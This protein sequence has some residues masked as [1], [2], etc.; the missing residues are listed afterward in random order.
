MSEK[1][2]ILFNNF[3]QI[4]L[5]DTPLIDVRAPIEFDKGAF[6]NAVNLPILNDEERHKVGIKY[7]KYGN[8]EATKLG[9]KLV[10]GSIREERINAWIDFI[11]TNN[12]ALLY[13]FRGGSRSKIARQWLLEKGIEITRLDGGYKAFRNFLL[14]EITG[15]FDPNIS[16]ITLGGHTGSGKTI[17]IKQLKNA[18][19]LEGL[20]NHR[21]SSFGNNVTPQPKQINFDNALAYEMIKFRHKNLQHLVVEDEGRNIGRIFMNHDFF[22]WFRSKYMVILDST[23]EERIENTYDEYVTKSQQE[24]IDFYDEKGLEM[25]YEYIKSSMIRVQKRLG[26]EKLKSFLSEFENAYTYQ[27]NTGDATKH[28][29]WIALFLR[30][31]YDPMYSYQIDESNRKLLFKGNKDEVIQFLNNLK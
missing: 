23:F 11:K 17:V 13:C 22:N 25:W 18:I 21:G 3:E 19:D 9:E 8:D 14:E 2:E 31:Y 6:P 30:D 7:K 10:S 26:L 5:C 27:L 28:K 12:N 4:A 15:D 16:P 1:K 29:G 24:H 20:A